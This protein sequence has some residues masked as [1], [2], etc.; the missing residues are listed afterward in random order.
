MIFLEVTRMIAQ[1]S[2]E[3]VWNQIVARAWSD[4]DFMNRLLAD[5]TPLLAEHHLVVPPGQQVRV[6]IGAEVRIDD[7]DQGRKFMLPARP[8]HE[9]MEEEL[10]GDVVGYY[11]YSYCAA[12]GYCGACGCRC[13][14]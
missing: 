14:C 7:T 3:L 6:E 8:E 10:V 4:E 12:S 1:P 13:Y 9:V 2:E 11:C 5:P